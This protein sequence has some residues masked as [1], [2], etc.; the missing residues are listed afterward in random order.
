[1]ENLKTFNFD[2]QLF[3]GNGDEFEEDGELLDEETNDELDVVDPVESDIEDGEDFEEESEEEEV[4]DPQE[5][6]QTPQENARMKKMRLKAEEDARKK[7]QAEKDELE[8]MRLELQIEREARAEKD[9][10]TQDAI[11]DKADSEGISESAAKKLLEQEV[12]SKVSQIKQRYETVQKQKEV[13]KKDAF[14]NEISPKMEEI[15]KERPELE[16]QT[17]F[18]FLKGQMGDELYKKTVDKTTKKTV[19]N[20]QDSMKRRSVPSS[21]SGEVAG[22]TS[23]LSSEGKEMSNAFGVDPREVAKYVR[24]MRKN[25]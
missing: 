4:A 22:D 2:L 6:K 24:S 7:L 19:A 20:I 14:Y 21:G 11:W 5:S 12:E 3:A 18:Y 1:M 15:L 13:L 25:K 16:P 10:I 8:K 9:K 17:V 23:I